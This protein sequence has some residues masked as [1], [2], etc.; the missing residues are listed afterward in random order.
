MDELL[1]LC[2]SLLYL[3]VVVIQIGILYRIEDYILKIFSYS[4]ILKLILI[5]N[6]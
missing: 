3:I 4:S 1:S 2:N 6:S 5:P